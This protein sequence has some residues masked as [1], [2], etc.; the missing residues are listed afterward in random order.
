VSCIDPESADQRFYKGPGRNKFLAGT[1][2]PAPST[3]PPIILVSPIKHQKP[4][5]TGSEIKASTPDQAVWDLADEDII[6][7]SHDSR[8]ECIS[9]GTYRCLCQDLEVIGV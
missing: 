3:E 4:A 9:N 7:T 6:G 5:N 1:V 2:S 8:C